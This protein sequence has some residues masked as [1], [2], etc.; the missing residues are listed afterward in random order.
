MMTNGDLQSLGAMLRQAREERALTFEEVEAQTRIRVK[1]LQALENGDLSLLPSVAHARGFLRNYAQF[2]RIDT[3]AVIASFGEVTGTSSPPVTAPTASP[4]TSQPVPAPTAPAFDPGIRVD[5]AD[6]PAASQPL[7]PYPPP[8]QSR[9]RATYVSPDQRVGPATP[10]G[11][12]TQAPRPRTFQTPP[13]GLTLQPTAPEVIQPE[14][15]PTDSHRR[16]SNLIT[17][18]V[19]GVGIV[20]IV[21]WVII[22][23]SAVRGDQLVQTPQPGLGG[24]ATPGPS[25]TL[26]PILTATL[27]GVPAVPLDRVLLNI[28]VTERTWARIVVDGKQEFEGQLAGGQVLQY[29]G[30]TSI[31]IVVGNAAAF[32]I[33]YNGQDLGPLGGRGE[34]VERIFTTS[35]QIT[36]TPTMTITP[37]NT[38][39]PIPTARGTV[40]PTPKP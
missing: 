22:Q 9:S 34:I 2:L 11:V 20:G 37:T 40:T 29:Q 1:F 7:T 12:A 21:A 18:A 10:A 39:V 17:G 13:Y 38:Q 23:L 4:I 14:S 3:N 26:A 19:L 5:R 33:N 24:T 31:T 28:T 16:Q 32:K 6:T 30:Q 27:G 35:G 15:V 25:P 8:T 36:P